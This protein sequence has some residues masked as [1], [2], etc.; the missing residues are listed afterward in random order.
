MTNMSISW[1]VARQ[2][3]ADEFFS[4][5]GACGSSED[6]KI[7]HE[8]YTLVW[9][10]EFD[11][12]GAVDPSKWK[13]IVAGDGFGNWEEQFYTDRVDNAWVSD[14]TLK[15]RARLENYGNRRFTSAKLESVDDWKYGK[16]HIRSRMLGVANG[17]WAAHWMHARDDVYGSWPHSGEIDIMEHVGHDSGRFFATVHTDAFHHNSQTQVGG[18]AQLDATSW[19][20]WTVEWRPNI[21]LFAA[22]DEVYAIFRKEG[23]DHKVWPFDQKFYAVLNLAV[24]GTW[25]AKGGIDEKAFVGNGQ[26]FEVDWVRV[27]QRPL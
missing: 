16:V 7:E 9:R 23:D 2:R 4:L 17:T 19:H 1:D 8:G 21:V 14:G 5:C 27:E 24:G 26:I 13:P 3:V 20:T 25:G 11:G 22:D 15:I 10:D 6:T 12:V 18:Y